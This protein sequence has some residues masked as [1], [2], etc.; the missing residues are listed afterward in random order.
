MP[1]THDVGRLYFHTF[2][3]PIPGAPLCERATTVEV[4]PPYRRGKAVCVRYTPRRAVVVGWWGK[5]SGEED[6]ALREAT[7]A[8]LL[9][10]P[11]ETILTWRAPLPDEEV[12]WDV[13]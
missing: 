1:E 8:I 3:Y 7:S 10:V 6:E 9:N 12:D 11:L 4:E 2:R 13:I 5:T